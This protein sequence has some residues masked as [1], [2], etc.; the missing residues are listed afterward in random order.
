MYVV[1]AIS[2]FSVA[3]ITHRHHRVRAVFTILRRLHKSLNDDNKDAESQLGVRR[4]GARLTLVGRDQQ[5]SPSSSP[6]PLLP[7]PVARRI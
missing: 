2:S 3:A 4:R 5:L 7:I 1:E 6:P